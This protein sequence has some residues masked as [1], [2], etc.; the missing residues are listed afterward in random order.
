[1][2]QYST[3]VQIP[4]FNGLN[5]TGDGYNMSMQYAREMEN[6]NVQGGAFKPMRTGRVLDQMLTAPIGTLAHLH[7]RYGSDT[8]TLLVAISDG[9]VY[10]KLLDGSDDWVQQYSGLTVNDC[11]WV[12]YEVNTYP[13]YS[14]DKTYA[15][16]ERC[17]H[18]DSTN[19]FN[20]YRCSTAIATAEDWTA[21]HWT[22]IT[23]T[24]PV[25]ILLFSNAT[26][27]MFCLYGDTK[28]VVAVS[29]PERF[30]VIAR[31]N[32]RIWGS[33][34]TGSPDKLMYSAPYDPFDWSAN[35][36]IPEDGAGDILQPTW[37]GDSFLALKQ[38]GSSLLAIKRNS[39]WRIYGTNPGEFTMQQ[40]YG[41]GTIE[42]NTLAV[43]N[44]YAYMLGEYGMLQYNGT[45]AF[46][47]LQEAV[48]TLMREQVTRKIDPERYPTYDASKV[49]FPNDRCLYNGNYYR[50]KQSTINS[51]GRSITSVSAVYRNT[52]GRETTLTPETQF[53][54]DAF[55]AQVG[56]D[57]KTPYIFDC[58]E[59]TPGSYAI[60]W[61]Y[62]ETDVDDMTDYGFDILPRTQIAGDRIIV[63]AVI[64]RP[65]D[66]NCWE[67]V[68]TNPLH[69]ACAGMWNG[70]YCLA[71]PVGG[72]DRC[73]AILQ[74]DTA[75]GS[76]S[77]RTEVSVDSFLQINE[78]LFYTSADYP[79]AVYE[80]D[81]DAGEVKFLKWAS[82]YQ[83]LGLKSSV[84]STFT[85]YLMVD[86]EVPIELRMG[87]RTEKKLKEKIFT[88]TPGK[89]SRV[90]LNT[91]G[92]I[93]RLEIRSY[94][95]APFSI[96]GGIK[97]DMELDPD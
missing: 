41:G 11:D 48:H 55:I 44:D 13:V 26:D 43:Y 67:L 60:K 92:R 47:F 9:K 2:A 14:S 4:A 5:Q 23:S 19:V 78:R 84:K 77:L 35:A 17:I 88:T 76:I 53:D 42:E 74:Y 93:F 8:G 30:G 72:V 39:V 91:H 94:T 58:E 90:R 38:Y 69:N 33:G 31:Y 96:A 10:T 32:E 29:T 95:A 45:G 86:S 54:T 52:Y 81:D 89:M 24:D 83:D 87:L 62:N 82:G 75:S 59:E 49:Y 71:L 6:V 7:R 25:D 34:I 97:I 12:T 20:A 37:D 70:V 16:G 22:A 85:A 46:P 65:F 51:S 79:G 64:T 18:E 15:V 50:C 1:M 61:V 80:L 27:G 21:A 68:D 63:T 57:I 28:Q 56:T 73:N 40:Q 3:T 36:E 66:S